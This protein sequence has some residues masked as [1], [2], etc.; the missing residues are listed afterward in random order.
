[1]DENWLHER[2]AEISRTIYSYCRAKTPSQQDAE[3]LSQD[4]LLELMKSVDNI[5]NDKAFYAFM[6]GVAGNVYKQWCRKKQ[7]NIAC[8]L[9]EN[10][11]DE[12]KIP[13]DGSSD[14]Y[15]LRRELTLLSERYRKATILYYIEG[16]SCS[17][18]SNLLAI[19]ES[20]VK[21]LLFKSRKKLKEGMNKLKISFG[22][23]K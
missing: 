5:R 14:I 10:I 8:E 18:I 21:Y 1:M 17:E 3:D 11:P 15:L 19:S 6:W 7:K 16:C 20:M 13:D 9:P 2:I 12:E 4:I 22:T 23:G